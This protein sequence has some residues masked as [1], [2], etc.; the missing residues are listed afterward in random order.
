MDLRYHG[1]RVPWMLVPQTALRTEGYAQHG[2]QCGVPHKQRPCR[3]EVG[4]RVC[5][6]GC[7]SPGP[8]PEVM[9]PR[10]LGS[11]DPEGLE[12]VDAVRTPGTMSRRP[13]CAVDEMCCSSAARAL[14]GPAGGPCITHVAHRCAH[15]VHSTPD[16]MI[17]CLRVCGLGTRMLD[18]A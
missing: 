11:R 15:H 7:M 16:T 9:D 14:R 3:R 5:P 6:P 10:D 17:W 12:M 4:H 2:P 18:P 8:H 13:S 1:I